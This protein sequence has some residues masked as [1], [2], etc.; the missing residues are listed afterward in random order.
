VKY[1]PF[2]AVFLRLHFA[3]LN[4]GVKNEIAVNGKIARTIFRARECVDP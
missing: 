2:A 1:A 4:T 3:I